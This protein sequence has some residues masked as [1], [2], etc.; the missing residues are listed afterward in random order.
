[1]TASGAVLLNAPGGADNSPEEWR[2]ALARLDPDIDFRVW[3]DTG[4]V[5]EIEFALVWR[6]EPGDL[7]RY[8][9]LKAIFNLGAGVDALLK[10]ASLP[11]DVPIVRLVDRGLTIGMTEY[12]LLHVLRYHRG[13]PELEAQQRRRE[14]TPRLYPLPWRRR[15]GILG[16]GVLGGDAATTL[17][18]LGFDVAGWSR[19]PKALPGVKGF[20]GAAGLIPFL[21]RS[22]ILVCLLPLTA[23]TAGILDAGA[24]AALPRGAAVIN[25]ARGGHVVE[26]DLLAALDSG[27]VGHATLDVFAEE[28]PPSDH[29]FWAHPRV[30]MT[31]HVASLTVPETAAEGIVEG[32]RRA[33]TGEALRHVVDLAQGY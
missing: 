25:A 1:M 27:Q 8:P 21:N 7:R 13:L 18:G 20:I 9:N 3:P 16:L 30:T 11:P 29:P 24:F 14:W 19:S 15:V 33:R 26:A 28:P 31:P 4:P 32:M 5:A 10:D 17:A 6:A 2:A 22:E 23:A 12:V